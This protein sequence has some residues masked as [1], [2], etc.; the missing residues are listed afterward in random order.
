VLAEALGA[1]VSAGT[2]G[3]LLAEGAAGLGGFVERVR[4]R[5]VGA[6]IAHFDETGASRS[7]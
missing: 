4:E 3:G 1:I 5:L 2:L 6:Q 7:S